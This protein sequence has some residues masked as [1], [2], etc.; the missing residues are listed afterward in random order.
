MNSLPPRDIGFARLDTDRLARTGDPEVVLAAHK[1]PE[2]TVGSLRALAAAHPGRA[3][4]ATRCDER[5]RAAC[6]RE[7]GE[8][9]IDDEGQTVVVGPLPVPSGTVA[10]VTAGTSDL[11]VARE[12]MT[13]AEVFGTTPTLIPDVGVAGLHRLLAE[14]DTL[15]AVD[16]IVA[17]AGTDGALPG[18]LAGL[19]GTPVIAVPTSVGYG[20]SLG[21]IA[22]LL[23]MLNACAPGLTVVNIDNGFG[24]A[25]AAA[26]IARRVG[27]AR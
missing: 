12:A 17:I 20:A 14:V 21:G 5:T 18:V 19:V 26:R 22:A 9:R 8:A 25:V 15:A 13:T 1:T 2:Q 4:L 11:P 23:T 27:G 7:F 6:R 3:V 10:V 24:A 16:A